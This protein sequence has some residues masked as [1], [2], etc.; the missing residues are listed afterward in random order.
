M[1]GQTLRYLKG[2]RIIKTDI[3]KIQDNSVDL[4]NLDYPFTQFKNS[5][6]DGYMV[7]GEKSCFSQTNEVSEINTLIKNSF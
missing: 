7:C 3:Q 4:A 6:E 2:D 5:D 1:L